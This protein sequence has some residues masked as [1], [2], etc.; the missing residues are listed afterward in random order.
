MI[1]IILKYL[2]LNI[3]LAALLTRTFNNACDRLTGEAERKS[4]AHNNL[5]N[6]VTTT[7]N[8][9]FIV[10]VVVFVVILV[11]M[12]RMIYDELVKPKYNLLLRLRT[13]L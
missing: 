5:L 11:R 10:K 12:F 4:A 1:K 9:V 8:D 13:I 2:V 6:R 7:S 3:M